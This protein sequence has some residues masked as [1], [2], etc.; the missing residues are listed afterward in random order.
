MLS[1]ITQVQTDKYG[2]IFFNFESVN[3]WTLVIG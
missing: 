2:T 1:K 3:D